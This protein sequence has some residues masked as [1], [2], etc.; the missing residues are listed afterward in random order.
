MFADKYPI[1][2][3]LVDV[4]L[5][6]PASSAICEQG[7]S[8]MKQI[9]SD[10]RSS[11]GK[12]SLV[13]LMRVLIHSPVIEDFNPVPAVHLWLEGGQRNRRP[14]VLPYGKRSTVELDEV[15]DSDTGCVSD[16]DVVEL[17]S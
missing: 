8:L 13:D 16:D 4:I 14:D 12:E 11:L 15:C 2:L 17:E 10:W 3:A 5:A 9:K 1:I 6:M 7:F